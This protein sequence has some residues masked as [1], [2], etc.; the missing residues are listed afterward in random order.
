MKGLGGSGSSWSQGREWK[1][2]G[3]ASVHRDPRKEK[4]AELKERI[5]RLER[6]LAAQ[7]A[8]Q[9]IPEHG[10][11]NAPSDN[12]ARLLVDEPD[13]K[14]G[15]LNSTHRCGP[16]AGRVCTAGGRRVFRHHSQAHSAGE[17]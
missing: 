2:S 13:K 11:N 8:G 1:R 15:R 10:V 16:R 14:R 4:N 17:Q 12:L 6:E 5:V 7:R 9:P 3:H